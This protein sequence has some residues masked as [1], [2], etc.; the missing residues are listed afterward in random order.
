ML[1]NIIVPYGKKVF[2]KSVSIC[3]I[4]SEN[5]LFVSDEG[6]TLKTLDYTIGIVSTPTFCNM[7]NANEMSYDVIYSTHTK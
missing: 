3:Q 4:C 1:V 7:K 6:P 5:R 2:S